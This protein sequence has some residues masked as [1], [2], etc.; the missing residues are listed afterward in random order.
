[1]LGSCHCTALLFVGAIIFSSV[2]A[3]ACGPSE[4]EVYVGGRWG[5]I[6]AATAPSGSTGEPVGGG[7]PGSV[8]SPVPYPPRAEPLPGVTAELWRDIKG[9][10]SDPWI[11]ARPAVFTYVLSGDVGSDDTYKGTDQRILHAR[12]N[13]DALVAEARAF[14]K[15]KQGNSL[16]AAN[17]FCIPAKETGGAN[18]APY[19]YRLARSYRQ[20]IQELLADQSQLRD[21]LGG[22]GPFLVATRL[23]VNEIVREGS[24]RDNNIVL[25][26]L[27]GAEPQSV[28]VFLN[29]FKNAVRRDDVLADKQLVPLRPAIVSALLRINAAIPFVG[30]AYATLKK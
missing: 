25:I 16:K 27:S 17:L 10:P 12:A 21:R 2:A 13:L 8:P 23:P 29:E 19:D 9:L 24:S 28:I 7:A 20:R 22:I 15:A 1:M 11:G 3:G 5:C 26:D 6:P 14:D 18:G 30:D 4:R